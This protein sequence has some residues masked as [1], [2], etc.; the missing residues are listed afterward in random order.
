[1]PSPKAASMSIAQ[2]AGSGIGEIETIPASGPPGMAAMV[3]VDPA[4]I[5]NVPALIESTVRFVAEVPSPTPSVAVPVT[6][7]ITGDP[8]VLIWRIPPSMAVLPL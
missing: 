8:T 2:V 3:T 4:L 5:V 6:L 7:C 1:M